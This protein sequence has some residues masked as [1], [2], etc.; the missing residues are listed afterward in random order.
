MGAID[1]L[2]LSLPPGKCDQ[3]EKRS[4]VSSTAVVEGH[5]DDDHP[6]LAPD[7]DGKRERGL[8]KISP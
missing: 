6:L 5:D 4:L 7:A 1:G 2:S 3:G 8:G